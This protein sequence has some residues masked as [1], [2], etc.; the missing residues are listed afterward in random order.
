MEL[1]KCPSFSILLVRQQL[2]NQ[3]YSAK[4]NL[5]T[6]KRTYSYSYLDHFKLR[7]VSFIFYS[8]LLFLIAY[9]SFDVP[10]TKMASQ[11]AEFHAT[12]CPE[13]ASKIS[14]KI[15]FKGALQSVTTPPCATT[16]CVFIQYTD[17]RGFLFI[18]HTFFVRCNSPSMH[19][20]VQLEKRVKIKAMSSNEFNIKKE[21]RRIVSFL[22]LS[23]EE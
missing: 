14:S 4:L 18:Q 15:Y 9:F 11:W 19:F 16:A 21:T 8:L 17:E 12:K 23:I 13:R 20:T 6:W 1:P 22:A 10:H 7:V 5:V 3:N 2:K